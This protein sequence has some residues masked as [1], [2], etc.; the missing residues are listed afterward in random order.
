MKPPQCVAVVDDDGGV[1]T[2]LS[3]LLR[4]L[5][6]EVSTHASGEAFLQALAAAPPACLVSDVRMPGMDGEQLLAALRASG[7]GLPVIFLTA[8]ANDAVR[9]RLLAAGA[10]ACL[11]KPAD[12]EVL[13]RCLDAALATAGG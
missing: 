2:S 12:A 10:C 9:A 3:S 5:G 1:R 6:Y 11:D 13:A 7:H 8:F 4:S